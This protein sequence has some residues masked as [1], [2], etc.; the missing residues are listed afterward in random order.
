[1]RAV[2]INI[3]NSRLR[4][5]LWTGAAGERPKAL[6]ADGAVPLPELLALPTPRGAEATQAVVTALNAAL[7][8]T[9]ADAAVVASVV[10]AAGEPLLAALPGA[11]SI[12]HTAPFSFTNGVDDPAAVG[13]DRYCNVAA[14]TAAGLSA[15][16]IVDCG[17]ATTFNLLRDGI[18]QGGLIAPGMALAATALGETAAR[19]APVPLAPCP[20]RVGRDTASAMAAGAYH[21]GRQ[22]VLGTVAALRERYGELPVIVTG[23]LGGLLAQTEWPYDPD[24]T[25]RGAACLAERIRSSG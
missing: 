23:G 12:D 1:M 24:W 22:G 6:L 10:P 21:V 7:E 3:G 9:G 17:T 16:L 25:A 19:L 15:A 4:A 13:A 18:F 5:S 2:V 11:L 8:S 14:A 20:L